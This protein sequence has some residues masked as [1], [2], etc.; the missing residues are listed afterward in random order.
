MNEIPSSRWRTDGAAPE[1]RSRPASKPA[2]ADRVRR[3]HA[4]TRVTLR[5]ALGFIA[6]AALSAAAVDARWLP[7]HLFLAGGMVL[8]ISG[9]SLMLTVTWSAA[10][11]PSD[12]W[13][14]WQRVA[15]AVGAAG[16]GIG[17]EAELADAVVG[18]SGALYVAGL[19][20]L[21]GLLVVTIRQGVE[22]RFDVAVAA[23]VLALTAGVVAVGVGIVMAV[24]GPTVGRRATHVTLNVL[25]LVGLVAGATMPF[26]AATVG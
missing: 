22:R 8:A 11:A 23:Y 2:A 5:L 20:T 17:R 3:S 4:Q 10:P 13:V 12:R 14:T 16:V 26:F 19:V 6:A 15:V 1:G 9:V 21:A 24:D 7:L 18:V 25:G